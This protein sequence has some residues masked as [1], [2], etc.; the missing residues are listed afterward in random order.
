[1]PLYEYVSREDGSVVELLRP[2]SR[3]DDP[4]PDPEGKG[5]TF[6][7]RLSTFA[8][9]GTQVSVGK[10]HVHTGGCACGKNAGPCG[11]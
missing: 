3:A 6:V 9:A 2:A 10:G 5:R 8:A 4:V 7:R 11:G 1:M